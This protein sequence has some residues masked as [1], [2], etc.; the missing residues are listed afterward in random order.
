[1]NKLVI[2]AAVLA[3]L[4][5]VAALFRVMTMES[6]TEPLFEIGLSEVESGEVEVQAAPPQPDEQ[7]AE[8]PGHK[9]KREMENISDHFGGGSANPR[10]GTEYNATGTVDRARK[11][12]EKEE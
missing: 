7:Q 11:N 4:L 1:M 2:V 5:A 9:R 12:L 6:D 8:K 10:G 3:V